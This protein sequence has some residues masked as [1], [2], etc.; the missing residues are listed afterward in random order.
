VN[1]NSKKTSNKYA[2]ATYNKATNVL[3]SEESVREVVY[4]IKAGIDIKKQQSLLM[5]KYS[6]LIYSRVSKFLV[7]YP[8]AESHKDDLLQQGFMG[9][10]EAVHKFDLDRTFYCKESRKVKHPKF[11]T[12]AF[13]WISLRVKDYYAK[14]CRPIRLSDSV[15][16][17]RRLVMLAMDKF[18]I[19]SDSLSTTDIVLISNET[20]LSEARVHEVYNMYYGLLRSID[21]A[22]IVEGIEDK[23]PPSLSEEEAV[24]YYKVLF[25][26]YDRTKTPETSFDILYASLMVQM[27]FSFLRSS[28][29]IVGGGDN[30]VDAQENAAKRCAAFYRR[31]DSSELYKKRV[32]YYCNKYS[33]DIEDLQSWIVK[34]ESLFFGLLDGIAPNSTQARS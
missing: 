1:K 29:R 25:A 11:I 17:D 6:S 14:N 31:L 15:M 4:K 12:C 23:R 16:K 18:E 8:D 7:M 26:L 34:N 9:L 3:N 30:E 32:S 13:S 2:D 21:I 24:R 27:L 5:S 33:V 20:G 10:F 22:S 28:T 19:D